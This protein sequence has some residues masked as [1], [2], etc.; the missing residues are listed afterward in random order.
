M[1]HSQQ[2][3]KSHTMTESTSCL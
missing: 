1:R 2:I 3:S